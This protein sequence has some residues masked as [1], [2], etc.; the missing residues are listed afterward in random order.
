MVRTFS[1][2]LG[3]T[4]VTLEVSGSSREGT[5][6]LEIPMCIM[7]GVTNPDVP[8]HGMTTLWC[9]QPWYVHPCCAY[10]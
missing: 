5:V 10:P 4:D 2:S 1:L 9:D 7:D 3:L 6:H 8:T